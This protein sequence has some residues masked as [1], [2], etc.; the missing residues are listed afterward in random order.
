MFK[1]RT[2]YYF[3]TSLVLITPLLLLQLPGKSQGSFT[4]AG[5]DSIAQSNPSDQQQEVAERFFDLLFSQQYE[6]ATQYIS[7]TVKSE[8]PAAVL[9]QKVEDF[10]RGTGAFVARLDSQVA[11][12]VVI[13]DLLFARGKRTFVVSFD[14]NLNI[15]NANYV[16]DTDDSTP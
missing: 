16:L 9:R 11:G 4:Q 15:L 3:F 14:E 1:E 7:P 12:D 10:Q 5:S 2:I 13:I 8:F 6:A